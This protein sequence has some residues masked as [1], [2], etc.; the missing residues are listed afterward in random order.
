MS[1]ENHDDELL[2]RLDRLMATAR[3]IRRRDRRLVLS[4]ESDLRALRTALHLRSD[5]LL[6]KLNIAGTSSK[7]SAAYSRI[8]SLRS[9]TAAAT[10][11]K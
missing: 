6:Q 11:I 9:R 10:T 2:R 3:T 7:A 1:S 4:L 5:A 8:A